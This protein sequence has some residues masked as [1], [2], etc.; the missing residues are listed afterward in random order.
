MTLIQFDIIISAV[1]VLVSNFFFP[2]FRQS[3]SWWLVPVLLVGIFVCLFILEA[4]I[5]LSIVA[6]T[7][8][9]KPPKNERFFRF[10]VKYVMPIIVAAVG[11]KITVEGSEKIPESNVLFV[12]NHQHNID[13]AIFYNYFSEKNISFI[14][15]KEILTNMRFV[16]K[17]MHRLNCL[18][19]D[20]ENDREAA[21]TVISAIKLLKDG[22][23]SIGLFPEGYSSKTCELLPFRNGSFKIATKSKVPIV[24]CVLNGTREVLKTLFLKRTPVTFKVLDVINP[25]VYENMSTAELGDMIHEKME[26]ALKEIRK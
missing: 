24:V 13:P 2:V 6:T 1:G 15:K 18:F 11:A 19:I 25:S 10:W 5:F 12:C 20:R 4:A 26:I 7:N 16:A 3:Y 21:K 22:K 17:A 9:D 23:H 8:L 14:G